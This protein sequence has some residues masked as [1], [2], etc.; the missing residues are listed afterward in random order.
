M[1]RLHNPHVKTRGEAVAAALRHSPLAYSVIVTD[2]DF[3]ARQAAVSLQQAVEDM[4]AEA[5]ASERA[6]VYATSPLT[7]RERCVRLPSLFVVHA[8]TT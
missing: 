1:F 4:E 5:T 8:L 3:E 7:K 6:A 2:P